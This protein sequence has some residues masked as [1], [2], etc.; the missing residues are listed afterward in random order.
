MELEA[1]LLDLLLTLASQHELDA[2]LLGL[3]L[4]LNMKLMLHCLIVSCIST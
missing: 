4:H 3:L 2:T 1:T